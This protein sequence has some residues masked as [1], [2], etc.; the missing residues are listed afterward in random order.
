MHVRNCRSPAVPNRSLDN[1]DQVSAKPRQQ[2]QPPPTARKN[3]AVSAPSPFTDTERTIFMADALPTPPPNHLEIHRQHLQFWSHIFRIRSGQQQRHQFQ[4]R[5]DWRQHS[6]IHVT[7]T[8]A[9]NPVGR[10]PFG[11]WGAG[12]EVTEI[13]TLIE[14]SGRCCIYGLIRG[15]NR[16]D[17]TSPC[18]RTLIA[19]AAFHPQVSISDQHLWA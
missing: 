2:Y 4:G 3:S 8:S 13:R 1:S 14:M 10:Y 12:I 9:M 7:C 11:R 15:Y 19:F 17:Q 5:V 16:H 6:D 18:Q